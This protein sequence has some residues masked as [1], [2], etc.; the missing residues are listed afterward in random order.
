[1]NDGTRRD[2]LAERVHELLDEYD[3]GQV[4]T[5]LLGYVH[6]LAENQEQTWKDDGQELDHL[7]SLWWQVGE[8]IEEAESI[9][10]LMGCSPEEDVSN[11][12]SGLLFVHDNGLTDDAAKAE[13][14]YNVVETARA[15]LGGQCN[16]LPSKEEPKKFPAG[17][18]DSDCQCY[19]RKLEHCPIHGSEP[20]CSEC[21][22]PQIDTPSGLTCKNGHGGVP[23][24]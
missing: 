11:V 1:M 23:S 22:E 13:L 5:A 2:I 7:H 4:L 10:H 3:V 8:S 21:G 17:Y 18:N 24:K 12:M 15:M 16:K 6:G 20:K 9:T 19:E 14:G